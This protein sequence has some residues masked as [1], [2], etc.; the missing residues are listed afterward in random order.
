MRTLFRGRLPSGAELALQ[1]NA[2]VD[3]DE[4]AFTATGLTP[5]QHLVEIAG[6]V[7]T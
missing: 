1:G 6:D 7:I 4:K 2:V 3:P 5:Q